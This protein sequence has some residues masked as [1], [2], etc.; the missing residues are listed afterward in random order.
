MADV[1]DDLKEL[2]IGKWFVKNK[3]L[4]PSSSGEIAPLDSV[5]L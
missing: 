5:T 1:A 2:A 3:I 4:W